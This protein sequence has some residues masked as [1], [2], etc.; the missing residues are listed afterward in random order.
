MQ[1]SAWSERGVAVCGVTRPNPIRTAMDWASG[2]SR[3][4]E[5]PEVVSLQYHACCQAQGTT[6]FAHLSEVL[7]SWSAAWGS[8]LRTSFPAISTGHAVTI[9]STILFKSSG[10][11]SVYSQRTQ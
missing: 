8:F 3:L 11:P 5:A 9:E 10:F 7:Q 1:P 6:M 4:L 2:V